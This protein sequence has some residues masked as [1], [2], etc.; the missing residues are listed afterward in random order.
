MLSTISEVRGKRDI[1]AFRKRISDRLVRKSLAIMAMALSWVIFTTLLL[2]IW[3]SAD[4]LDLLF[5]ATSAFG[6]V[7]ISRNLTSSLG[8]FS[9][10]ILAFSM[11]AGR[12]GLMTIGI[13]LSERS[14]GENSF[15]YAEGNLPVG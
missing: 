4:F 3:E 5:E 9:K 13:A 7:G 6:T 8:D 12:V 11:F 14:D 10:I 15:R 1:V 2:S